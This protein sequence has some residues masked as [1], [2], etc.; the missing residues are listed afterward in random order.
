MK[1]LFL[2]TRKVISEDE[3]SPRVAFS[4]HLALGDKTTGTITALNHNSGVLFAKATSNEDGTLNA[5]CLDDVFVAYDYDS[6][7]EYKIYYMR[8]DE[9]GKADRKEGC[10]CYV[11][12][13]DFIHYSEPVPVKNPVR[14]PLATS[15]EPDW[16]VDDALPEGAIFQDYLEIEDDLAALLVKKLTTPVNVANI[17]PESITASAP[18][19]IKA[20]KAV[21]KYSDGSECEKRVDWKLEGIDFSKSGEVTVSG[22]IH[23]EHFPFPLFENRADPCVFKWKDKFYFIAT[24]DEDGNHTTYVR[25]ADTI[26]GLK[27]AEPVCILDSKTYD[28]IG[29]LLWAPEFHEIDGRLYIFMAAT[30]GE[31]FCEESRI[32]TLK[33][34]GS[35]I[36]PKDWSA[37]ERIVKADGSELCEEGKVISLD[38]TC[39]EWEGEMYV[40]WS[41]R[42][43]LPVDQGAWLLMAKLNREQPWKLASEPVVLT[44]PEYSFENNHTYVVEGPFALM[45]DN[46]LYLTYSGAA[47]DATYVVSM[48]TIEKGKD[49]MKPENWRKN[50]YPILCAR[51]TPGEYGTGHNA[52]VTDDD[53]TVYN[54][55]HARPGID[56]PRSTGIRR[57]HFG[58]DGEPILDMHEEEDLVPELANVSMKVKLN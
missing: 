40:V 35:P 8:T 11:T 9:S 34:G 19:D 28:Y 26:S 32:L 41:Q 56:G 44:K 30:K 22:K 58:F 10:Q 39:F 33:E 55:Y 29:G 57:V 46:M 15:A 21:A 7:D 2:Y 16:W 52:Y 23:Q 4:L 13:K 6:K 18:E 47:V 38:M 3:Y 50:N 5:K 49:L 53:G 12:T 14:R 42:Q 31:F 36:N 45:R 43:F 37:P 25:E 17:V 51:S 27:D 1:T 48:M 20:V 54:T 24:T